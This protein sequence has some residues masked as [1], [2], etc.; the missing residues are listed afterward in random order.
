MPAQPAWAPFLCKRS[1]TLDQK[2]SRVASSRRGFLKTSAA[3]GAGL[4]ADLSG[5]ANV[6]A[7]GSDVIRVG[8]IGCGSPR[9]GRGRG[10]AEQCVNGGA[11]G[12]V[13]GGGGPVWR[14]PGF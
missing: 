14:P 3:V 11:H 4:A 10:A 13:V 6:H 5:A 7:A 12:Q 1:G 8:L 2:L 9:G